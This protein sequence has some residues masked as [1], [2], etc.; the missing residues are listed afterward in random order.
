MKISRRLTANDFGRQMGAQMASE[1]ALLSELHDAYA[2]CR[3]ELLDFIATAEH[4]NEN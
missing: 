3:S 1:S 4:E 2:L